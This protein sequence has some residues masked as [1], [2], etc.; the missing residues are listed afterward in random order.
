MLGFSADVWLGWHDMPEYLA[1]N[2]IGYRIKN[3]SDKAEDT[4]RVRK[5]LDDK[6]TANTETMR[7]AVTANE[8]TKIAS[9][10]TRTIGVHIKSAKGINDTEYVRYLESRLKRLEE[11]KTECLNKFIDKGEAA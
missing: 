3:A 1:D 6:F 11:I 9:S 2:A 4:V 10:L 8:V 5:E 7:T